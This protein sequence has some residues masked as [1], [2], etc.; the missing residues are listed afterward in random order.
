MSEAAE[1]VVRS[2]LG[3]GIQN[4]VLHMGLGLALGA[5]IETCLPSY[6]DGASIQSQALELM[7]Q[8]GLNGCALSV[9]CPILRKDD[10]TC[11]MI[12]GWALT[13]AQPGLKLRALAVVSEARAQASQGGLRML[14]RV[15]KA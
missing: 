2:G 1:P 8:S 9:V 10:P 3:R 15:V 6:V 12:F 11:G 5:I 7:V 14:P 13:L 4:S